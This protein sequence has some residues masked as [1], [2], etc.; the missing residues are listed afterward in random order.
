MNRL[1]VAFRNA[2]RRRQQEYGYSESLEKYIDN[3]KVDWN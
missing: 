1:S 2:A 3:N